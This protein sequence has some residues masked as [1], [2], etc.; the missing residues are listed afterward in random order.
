MNTISINPQPLQNITNI[1][2]SSTVGGF[3][4]T[5]I[6]SI[7]IVAPANLNVIPSQQN[8]FIILRSQE[9]P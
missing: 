7:R 1:S 6:K 4:P 2:S 3:V 8:Q 9:N 5:A